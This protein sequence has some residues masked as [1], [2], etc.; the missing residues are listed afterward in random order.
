MMR[1][2][3]GRGLVLDTRGATD[4]ETDRRK[5]QMGVPGRRHRSVVGGVDS[6]MDPTFSANDSIHGVRWVLTERGIVGEVR[7]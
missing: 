3:S 2:K 1:V 4:G 7:A 6:M 5:T